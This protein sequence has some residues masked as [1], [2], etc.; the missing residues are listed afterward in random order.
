MEVAEEDMG[1]RK[2]QSHHLDIDR[3]GKIS[4]RTVSSCTSIPSSLT[5]INFGISKIAPL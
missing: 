3:D 1:C 4:S 2:K 5:S